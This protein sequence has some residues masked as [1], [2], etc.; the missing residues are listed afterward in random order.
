MAARRSVRT[1]RRGFAVVAGTAAIVVAMPS[2]AHAHHRIGTEPNLPYAQPATAPMRGCQTIAGTPSNPSSTAPSA[3]QVIYAWHS[4]DGDNYEAS[5][6][7]IARVVDRVDWLLDNTSNYDQHIRLSCR[8]TPD[9]SYADY[10]RAL[11]Q[12]EQIEAGANPN[13]PTGTIRDDLT[14]SGYNDANRWYLVFAD[15]ASGSDATLC[16]TSG[17]CIAITELWDAGVAGH[18]LIHALG[19]GHSWMTENNEAF[20]P[21][22]MTCWDSWWLADGGFR[23]YYDPSETTANFYI[24]PWPD[25]RIWNI[26]RSPALETP[27]CC[28]SGA[29]SDLLTGHERTVEG[30][31]TA[32]GAVPAGFGTTGGGTFVVTPSCGRTGVSCR[33]FDGRKSLQVTTSGTLGTSGF[34]VAR[35]PAVVAG[36]TYR[37]YIRMRSDSARS[38]NMWIRYFNSTGGLISG[39]GSAKTLTTN[40]LEHR[41]SVTAPAGAVA[42]HIGVQTS[43]TVQSSFVFQVDSIQF[44][45][46]SVACRPDF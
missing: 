23:T 26:T 18:E 41:T 8:Y 29:S 17:G 11:V 3:I 43:S 4:G 9:G 38:V 44:S 39:V 7:T 5:Y 15:F 46:C 40:W 42:A 30:G 33:Y 37:F 21:D 45:D 35:R 32:P 34:N 25:T 36:R 10:A 20:C 16:F 31:G 28:D 22:I 27:T 2:T 6:Q 24:D 1:A 13:T 19:A 12:K 14:A